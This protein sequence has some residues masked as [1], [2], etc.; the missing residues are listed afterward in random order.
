M[1]N[2]PTIHQHRYPGAV[3]RSATKSDLHRISTVQALANALRTRIFEGELPPAAPLREI[4]LAETYG[5]ARHCVHSALQAL[6]HEGLLRHHPNRGVFV[7]QHTSEDIAD[8]HTIR[9]AI[10]TEAVRI[11]CGLGALLD[12][13]HQALAELERRVSDAPWSDVIMADLAVH[14]AIV[15]SANSVRMTRAHDSLIGELRLCLASLRE[16]SEKRLTMIPEHR[17][18]V[19]NMAAG[20]TR[21]A[22]VL[23][24]VHLEQAAVDAV[25]AIAAT[26]TS[27]EADEPRRV[28]ARSQLLPPD[29]RARQAVPK[30]RGK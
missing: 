22:V 13:A 19:M 9:C 4:E 16:K 2:K 24:R 10:E 14:Q 27:R 17:E 28:A 25:A 11:S 21:R 8:L 30:R 5:V 18:I 29:T 6:V 12:A 1:H 20:K 15:R 23:L 26:A 3:T 7:A